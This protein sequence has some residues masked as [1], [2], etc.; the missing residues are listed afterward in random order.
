MRIWITLLLLLVLG[1]PAFAQNEVPLAENEIAEWD[2]MSDGT[3]FTFD[4]TRL[5][6]ELIYPAETKEWIEGAFLHVTDGDHEFRLH[7]EAGLSGFGEVG[8]FTIDR[9]GGHSIVFGAYTGGAHCC[10]TVQSVLLTDEGP[11]IA[12]LGMY[13]GDFIVPEDLDGDGLYE[14]KLW[15]S[16]FFYT[17]DAY[18]NSIPPVLIQDT[19]DGALRDVTTEPDYYPQLKADMQYQAEYCGGPGG[20]EA[21]ACAALAANAARVGQYESQR[22]RIATYLETREFHSGWD[23]FSFC[24]D[25]DC[26]TTLEFASFVE[27]LDYAL[28]DWGYIPTD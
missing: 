16:R 8:I 20:W 21:S 14:F 15:D 23:E 4:D 1:L 10:M 11:V 27:A 7:T 24:E 9:S 3:V 6:L 13:D 12:D 5:R 22:E 18:A 2:N 25:E 26:T 17:F 19:Q 28:K